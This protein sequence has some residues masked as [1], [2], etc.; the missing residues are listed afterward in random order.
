MAGHVKSSCSFMI[1]FE[2]PERMEKMSMT[3][4]HRRFPSVHQPGMTMLTMMD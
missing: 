3:A 4:E 2:A 1:Q